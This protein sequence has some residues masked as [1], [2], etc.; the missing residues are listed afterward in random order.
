MRVAKLCKADLIAPDEAR[1]RELRVTLN[2]ETK[3]EVEI[4][5]NFYF[6]KFY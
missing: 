3:D 6:E 4:K 5:K 1:W 2:I